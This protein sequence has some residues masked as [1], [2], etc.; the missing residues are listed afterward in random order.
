MEAHGKDDCL[1]DNDHRVGQEKHFHHL[2]KL[3]NKHMHTRDFGNIGLKLVGTV[4]NY[5]SKILLAIRRV[6]NP[7]R[8]L[9]NS[10]HHI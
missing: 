1:N 6:S 9:P 5:Y 4:N 8:L 3:R 7:L 10:S 2:S